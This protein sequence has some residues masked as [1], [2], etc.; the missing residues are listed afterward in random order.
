VNDFLY[1]FHNKY[2]GLAAI[3]NAIVKNRKLQMLN[4]KLYTWRIADEN[5]SDL[6][7]SDVPLKEKNK[8]LVNV[9]GWSSTQDDPWGVATPVTPA[10]LTPVTSHHIEE[11]D[12]GLDR[13]LYLRNKCSDKTLK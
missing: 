8:T 11:A 12:A 9:L 3:C 7:Y 5:D 1:A 2:T 6:R 4:L 13:P 10:V